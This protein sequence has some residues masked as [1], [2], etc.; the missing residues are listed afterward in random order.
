MFLL[1][2]NSKFWKTLQTL[3]LMQE[4]QAIF[5]R[6]RALKLWKLLKIYNWTI[7]NVILMKLMQLH[8]FYCT[9]N[10]SSKL[11]QKPYFLAQFQKFFIYALLGPT[12]YA[13]SFCQ[14]KGFMKLDNRGKFHMYS[15]CGYQV[16]KFQRF[17]YRFSIHEMAHFWEG[18]GFGTPFLAK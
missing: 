14:N 2:K 15:I 5:G 10:K 3:C 11:I 12:T 4:Y 1:R 18:G 8:R 16:T 7:T 13:P 9:I 6:E 17:S